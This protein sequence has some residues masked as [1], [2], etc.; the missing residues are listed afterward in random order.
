MGLEHLAQGRTRA[1]LMPL[2]RSIKVASGFGGEQM[3]TVPYL[4]EKMSEGNTSLVCVYLPSSPCK[5]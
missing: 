1:Q 2:Y 4:L 5:A 3:K